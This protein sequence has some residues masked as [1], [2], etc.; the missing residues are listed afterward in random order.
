MKTTERFTR[1]LP[2]ILVFS[3]VLLL[4]IPN[5]HA[6]ISRGGAPRSFSAALTGTVQT[7]TTPAVDLTR[8]RAEDEENDGTNSPIRFAIP[9]KVHLTLENAGTW[10][11]LTGGDR[12]WRLRAHCPDAQSINF[13]YDDFH[14]PEGGL[15]YL[16]TPDH[17]QVLGAFGA[18]NNRPYSGFATA[19]TIGDEIMLEYFEP[20]ADRGR[21]RISIAQIAHGYRFFGEDGSEGL[22]DGG[23][24]QVNVNCSP[25]GD[26]WQVEKKS[27]A[28]IVVNGSALCTGTLINNSAQDC[29]PYF[30][31]ANHCIEGSYDAVTNPNIPGFVFYWNYERPGC[32]NTG[33][34]PNQTTSGATVVANPSVGGN[35]AASSDFALLRLT[36]NP[37][38][39][40]D[41]YFAGFDASG[42]PG[43]GGVGIHHPAGDAKKIAT[44]N[45]TPTSVVSDHFWRIF[46]SQTPNGWS[47]TEGGSSG[48]GLFNSQKRLIG[49]LFGGFA[50]GQ[51]NCS[52]P[53]NDEGDYGKLSYSWNNNGATDSRRRLRDWLDPV[54]GGSIT[55]VNGQ[56]TCVPLNCQISGAGLSN[57]ACHDNGT[58]T[59]TDDYITFTL[60]PTGMDIGQS[61]SVSGATLTPNTGVYGAPTTFTAAAGSASGPNLNLTITDSFSSGCQAS[62]TVTPP[63]ACSVVVP[64]SIDNATITNIQCKDNDTPGN[65]ADDY[66]SFQLTVTGTNT[67]ST[68]RVIGPVVGSNRGSYGVPKGFRTTAGTAGNGNITLTIQDFSNASCSLTVVL[69]DPGS[70]SVAIPDCD[71]TGAGLSGISCNN[72]GTAANDSDDRITFN[73]SP[74]GISLGTQYTVSGTGVPT[75]TGVYGQVS[76][77]TS[78]PGTAGN[79]NLTLKIIDGS[80][81]GCQLTFTVTDP[82]SCSGNPPPPVCSLV[83]ANL[84]GVACQD[85]GTPSN[86]ADDYLTFTLNPSGSALGSGYAVSGALLSP[87]GGAYGSAT[88]FATA[89]G[90]A[91]GGNLNLTITDNGTAG[92]QLSFTVIN[93]GTCSNAT[94]PDCSVQ[95]AVCQNATI[96]IGSNGAAVLDPQLLA[97]GPDP[98]CE[99]NVKLISP[100]SN[101]F[102]CGSL[103]I[104]P[105]TIR[106]TD[107]NGQ[108][109]T[110]TVQ[111]T[112]ADPNGYCS[113]AR[114]G[115]GS[116]SVSG[117]EAVRIFPNP[118]QDKVAFEFGAQPLEYE[119][120]NATGGRIY[121]AAAED[122]TRVEQDISNYP[123][124]LY[125]LKL[126]LADGR[127]V[128]QRFIIAR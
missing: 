9:F 7:V 25:E 65:P 76:A 45:I 53:A 116:S 125:F 89:P 99:Y 78:N 27:V 128:V 110:C 16:Y 58:D 46:W 103:G 55:V 104:K 32:P 29:T 92:C 11:E 54:G 108:S 81:T 93:P 82:G 10:T 26:N 68:Y 31:T 50:G 96:N 19:V 30:L 59:P 95:A 118:A 119:I 66:I 17:N 123:E 64:C 20:A 72:N 42:S 83:S 69:T 75:Q 43:T 57:I 3:F 100:R 101:V 73:L 2:R 86:P 41:V 24:C 67:G 28:R 107:S 121:R 39:V 14:M 74:A 49:Q 111:V 37:V 63:G 94:G 60:N 85:N 48:S 52:D 36:S 56:S 127:S 114:T 88:T 61:Y 105:V 109:M 23:A 90:S 6:Q 84:S 87:A 35:A 33:T 97:A 51:P 1:K 62:V 47:V 22:G 117:D 102:T 4:L 113:G 18:H 5:L 44:H 77:F 15:F 124:G 38:D 34:P 91:N 122:S 112:V 120:I 12:I 70:C 115:L 8:V 126:T 80:D 106:V 98:S 71:L 40:Y 79:G 21:G 13:L